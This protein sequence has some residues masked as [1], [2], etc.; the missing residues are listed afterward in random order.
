MKFYM[1]ILI[2]FFTFTTACFAGAPSASSI[3]DPY[4]AAHQTRDVDA[5]MALVE[6]SP[7]TPIVIVDQTRASFQESLE[8]KVV[9]VAVMPLEEEDQKSLSTLRSVS[10]PTLEPVAKFVVQWD[11][12]A[13][14]GPAKTPS[15]TK[16]VGIKDGRYRFVTAKKKQ[17]N[18]AP[19]PTTTA[20]TSAAEQPLVPAAVVA[21]L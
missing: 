17:P 15:L 21:H 16:F 5:L 18:K 20:G 6:F 4:L 9:G 3:V 14:S 7:D 1:R 13:Q 2:L 19:E 11:V 8:L 12:D 10:D